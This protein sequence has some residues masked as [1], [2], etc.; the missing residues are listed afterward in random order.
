MN[1]GAPTD[2]AAALLTSHSM[3]EERAESN[4]KVSNDRPTKELSDADSTAKEDEGKSTQHAAS[5]LT[6]VDAT[7]EGSDIKEHAHGDED[8]DDDDEEGD[9]DATDGDKTEGPQSGTSKRRRT[10][11]DDD[12]IPLTFPQKVHTAI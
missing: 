4:K 5:S 11:R 10:Q 7:K 3:N 1:I 8:G 9:D 12:E 2:D 6:T